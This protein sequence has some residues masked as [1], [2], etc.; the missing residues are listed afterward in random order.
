M[1]PLALALTPGEPAGIG[2]DITVMLAQTAPPISI[3]AYADPSVLQARAAQLSMPLLIHLLTEP[4]T[5]ELPLLPAGELYVRPFPCAV[6]VHPGVL[7][8]RNV[9]AVMAALSAAAQDCLQCPDR[10]ALVTGPIQKSVINDA[11]VPFTGHTEFLQA[12]AGVD[13]VVMMLATQALRVALVTTH[14]PLRDVPM[15]ITQDAVARTLGIVEHDLR[16]FF[17]GKTP[18]MLVCGLNPHAGEGGHLGTEDRDIIQPVI[19]A[20]QARG[21][22]VIGPVP[23]DTAFTPER[24]RE[25]DVVVSMYHDQGLPVLKAS[26]F[27]EAI[28]VTLGL[29]CIRTSVD[30]GTALSLAGTGRASADSLV[31][32]VNVATQMLQQAG[33]L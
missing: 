14:L 4:L 21:W 29:P 1:M 8:V 24:L 3:V 28:N 7:D 22:R 19:A 10:M 6:E 23:A 20:C 25:V 26:G 15:A 17:V 27:G 32:A 31:C 11:G 12:L 5:R 33:G 30:H 9:P 13:K 18:C 16:V 2:P